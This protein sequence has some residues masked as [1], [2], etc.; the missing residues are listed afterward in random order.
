MPSVIPLFGGPPDKHY[1]R[2]LD[3]HASQGNQ[4]VPIEDVGVPISDLG[5]NGCIYIYNT[6][7]DHEL[8]YDDRQS[9]NLIAEA[10]KGD[11]DA[12][13]VLCII[14]AKHARVGSPLSQQLGDYVSEILEQRIEEAKYSEG[15][16]KHTNFARNLRI[17]C[18]FLGE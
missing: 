3:E 13:A 17:S 4:P 16:N 2:H 7:T 1:P 5:C 15:G 14:A 12:D 8:I 18:F 6:K 10:R 9:E 11:R